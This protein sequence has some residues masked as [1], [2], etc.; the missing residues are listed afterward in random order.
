[1]AIRD[2]EP[3]TAAST[4][5]QITCCGLKHYVVHPRAVAL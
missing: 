1:M 2:G 4:F 5:T 3:K